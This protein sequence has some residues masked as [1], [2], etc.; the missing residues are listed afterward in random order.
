MTSPA[1]VARAPAF[2]RT[3]ILPRQMWADRV[4]DE[5]RET[6]D[7]VHLVRVF[8]IHPHTAVKYVAAAHPDK[9]L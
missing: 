2:D 9:A 4:L 6:T 5:A 3:G 7:P 1:P 8:G